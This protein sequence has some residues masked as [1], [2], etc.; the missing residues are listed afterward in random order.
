M[1]RGVPERHVLSI[2]FFLVLTYNFCNMNTLAI[3]EPA[4]RHFPIS[5]ELYHLMAEKGLFLPTDRTEL[6]E[7]EIFD[8]SPIGNL[9][10]RCVKF[11][12][13]TLFGLLSGKFVIGVQD[14]IILGD[15]SEPQPD[16]SILRYRADFYKNYAPRETDVVLVIEVAETSVDFDRNIKFRRYASAGIPEAWLIDISGERIEIH[17]RPKANGYGLVKM[18]LRGENVVSETI[19]AINLMVDD[20]LG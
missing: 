18:Y 8:M 14:P 11:L 17:T 3:Q 19:P 2:H 12:A 6:I 1:G 20:I 13:S 9:H 10:A 16:I 15:D 5:V 7:G 4:P